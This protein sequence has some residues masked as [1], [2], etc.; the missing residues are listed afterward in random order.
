MRLDQFYDYFVIIKT[1]DLSNEKWILAYLDQ[2]PPIKKTKD[3]WYKDIHP[4]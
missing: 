4:L 2:Y 1:L 3:I